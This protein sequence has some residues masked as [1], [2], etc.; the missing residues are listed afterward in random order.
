MICNGQSFIGLSC[1]VCWCNEHV[2]DETFEVKEYPKFVYSVSSH[3]MFVVIFALFFK[4]PFFFCNGIIHNFVMAL[5]TTVSS[6]CFTPYD[7][8]FLSTRRVGT[9]PHSY[10]FDKQCGYKG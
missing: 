8:S 5:F 6:S 2:K 9:H 3:H 7:L 10:I 1:F 4:T